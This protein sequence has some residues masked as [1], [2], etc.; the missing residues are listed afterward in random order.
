MRETCGVE[1]GLNI[2]PRHKDL[3]DAG[4]WPKYN[5][6]PQRPPWSMLFNCNQRS[7]QVGGVRDRAAINRF[8]NK[9]KMLF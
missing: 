9:G 5:P 7:C 1:N 6:A 4:E 8:L 2:I 3:L